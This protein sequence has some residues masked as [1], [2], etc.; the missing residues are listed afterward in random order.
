MENV[1]KQSLPSD[2]TAFYNENYARSSKLAH[3]PLED[4]F[5]YGQMLNL[6]RPYLAPGRRAFDLGC[7][8][9][10]LS[11]Y[12]A[13]KGCDVLGVDLAEN[14]VAVATASAAHHGIPNAEFSALDF[15]N[16][17]HRDETF[18][19]VLASH[20]IE[21]VPDDGA[22][23]N[24]LASIL[25]PDGVLLL[26]TPIATSSLAIVSTKL[27]GRFA[28]DEQVGHLRRYQPRSLA[29]M[30]TT[31]GLEIERMDYLDG[32]LR[33]WS[34]LWKPLEPLNRLWSRRYLRTAFN[35]ADAWL[36]GFCFPSS[37]FIAARKGKE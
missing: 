24:K 12:M 29:E 7:N 34:L 5:M 10:N 4:D 16:N 15:L 1:M 25:R 23:L 18:D 31:S 27:T 11:L 8:N 30:V 35:V 6:M 20:V 19:V 22:L 33:D 36:A 28:H 21:H 26:F 3:I 14:A 37:I 9:G 13:R 17:W 32:P 2:L